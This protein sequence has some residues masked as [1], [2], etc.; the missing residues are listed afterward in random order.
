[1]YHENSKRKARSSP[2]KA[3]FLQFGDYHYTWKSAEGTVLD[4]APKKAGC[5]Q[6]VVSVVN[7]TYIGSTTIPFCD[8]QDPHHSHGG[9]HDRRKGRHSHGLHFLHGTYP[10]AMILSLLSLLSCLFVVGRELQEGL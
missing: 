9:Q 1:M 4:E 6:L 2:H 5:Y 7:D 3:D 10:C 8:R